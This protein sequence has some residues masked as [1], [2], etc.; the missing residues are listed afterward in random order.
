MPRKMKSIIVVVSDESLPEIQQV[1]DNLKLQ[2]MEVKQVLPISGVITGEIGFK[3]ILEL[4]RI[5]GVMNVEIEAS[6]TLNGE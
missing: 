3:N 6:A 4:S 1:A 2:G 5:P